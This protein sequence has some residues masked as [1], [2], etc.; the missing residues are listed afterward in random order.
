MR[1]A[2][3]CAH[4]S[5]ENIVVRMFSLIILRLLN[6]QTISSVLIHKRRHSWERMLSFSRIVCSSS[7]HC[8]R[9]GRTGVSLSP[10]WIIALPE[11]I[12]HLC[13]VF[14]AS[15]GTALWLAVIW[16]HSC[17]SNGKVFEDCLGCQGAAVV[18]TLYT[19]VYKGTKKPFSDKMREKALANRFLVCY[20]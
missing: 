20:N 17:G 11:A 7:P 10:L 15:C 14:I 19:D 12:R 13:S 9:C 3:Y 2:Y 1:T 18:F 16:S 5:R 4:R 6:L 8:L